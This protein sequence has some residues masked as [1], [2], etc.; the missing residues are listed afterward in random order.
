MLMTVTE[1]WYQVFLNSPLN[2]FQRASAPEWSNGRRLDGA[3]SMRT[4]GNSGA[5]RI[6]PRLFDAPGGGW[7]RNVAAGKQ[8][9]GRFSREIASKEALML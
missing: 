7:M 4:K 5:G 1:L 8:M 3:A 6:V 9:A 2:S